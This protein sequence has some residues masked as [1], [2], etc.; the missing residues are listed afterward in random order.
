VAWSEGTH[1]QTIY[2]TTTD[3]INFERDSRGYA[4]W[5]TGDDG[6]VSAYREGD[7][8]YLFSGKDVHEMDLSGVISQQPAGPILSGGQPDPAFNDNAMQ[9][10]L[11]ADSGI[12]NPGGAVS[13]WQDRSNHGND[14]TQ[15]VSTDRPTHATDSFGGRDV[16]N[17]DGNADH[18]DF[19]TGFDSVFDGSFT[20]FVLL[21]PDDGDP[22]RDNTIFGL[23]SEDGNDRM[24]L[25]LDGND[26]SL[27][28]L[29]KTDGDSANNLIDPL[30][31]P[32]GEQSKFTL[33]SYVNNAGGMHY[34]YV[35]GNPVPAAIVD[36]SGVINANFAS[37]V[38]TAFLGSAN[39]GS[40]GHFPGS[41]RTWDGGI[42]EF[43]LYDGAL[44]TADREAVEDYLLTADREA[45][46]DY[47]LLYPN[48]PEPLPG[49]VNNDGWV[50]GADL[51]TIISYWGQSGLGRQF[52]DLNGN[53]VVDGP[54]YT[55]VL[56]YWGTGTPP[57]PEAT[58]EP[59]T[60]GLLVLA[61][62]TVLRRR[63]K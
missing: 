60:L 8:L 27:N 1:P 3:F 57:P 7:T 24:V 39:D 21:A 20:M 35:D 51:S 50:S 6:I 11:R 34:A 38:S 29:Y 62:L 52:G 58:P 53:G 14:A 54:D 40:G 56:S 46:E 55:E 36:G 32:D 42:A 26:D 44:S 31:W 30:P 45:V 17:F 61:G 63:R 59:A 48:I 2:S 47:L 9:V 13:V 28:H 41:D 5:G 33:I 49:D 25:G 10:W 4:D 43:I 15:S 12:D 18:L 16:V 23:V 22:N 19:G 37:G